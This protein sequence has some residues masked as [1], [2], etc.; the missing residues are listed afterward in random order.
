[1]GEPAGED[2]QDGG[3]ERRVGKKRKLP[4][5][6]RI[7]S[8]NAYVDACLEDEEGD[9]S[10]ADLEDFIVCRKGRRY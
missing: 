9:D 10:Y 8:R 7:R 4:T 5:G 1:M 2:D 6:P 3:E